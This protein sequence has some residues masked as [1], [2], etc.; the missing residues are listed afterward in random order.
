[1][2]ASNKT[3]SAS[4]CQ[5][6][7][8]LAQ[9]LSGACSVPT[10]CVV[11]AGC[12]PSAWPVPAQCLSR[13]CPAGCLPGA[14]PVLAWYLSRACPVPVQGS[15]GCVTVPAKQ[16][17]FGCLSVAPRC[18]L[19]A[20]LTL[21]LCPV[22]VSCLP[23]ACRVPGGNLPSTC[24]V[25]AQAGCLSRACGACRFW[26]HGFIKLIQ[27]LILAIICN[28]SVSHSCSRWNSVVKQICC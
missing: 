19:G 3:T 21:S 26:I 4:L 11:G 25:P 27:S 5:T 12:L 28:L 6:A 2:P 9:C 16:A 10:Q 23:S 20:C 14:S 17:P 15:V 7:L 13:A 24:W 8:V 18:L 22:P 1:M